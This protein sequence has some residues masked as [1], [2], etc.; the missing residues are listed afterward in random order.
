[1]KEKTQVDHK[2]K[3]QCGAAA[4]RLWSAKNIKLFAVK[5]LLLMFSCLFFVLRIDRY[6][7]NRKTFKNVDTD[8]VTEK[9]MAV[10]QTDNTLAY[11]CHYTNEY[12]IACI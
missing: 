6:E 7:R 4:F 10:V 3:K 9:L 11:F 12:Y 8:S 5:Y 2:E 1:M